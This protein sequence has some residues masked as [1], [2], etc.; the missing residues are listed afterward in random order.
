MDIGT[1]KDINDYTVGGR[2]I[3][4]HLIDIVDPGY[5]YNLFEY[6]QDFLKAYNDIISRK[7]F[8]VICGGSGMYVD[9]IVSGYRLA[10]VPPD[11]ILRQEL[12]HLTLEELTSVLST[13]KRMHNTTDVDS[14]K[15]AIRAI[16]IEKYYL[17]LQ[18]EEKEFP[19]IRSLVVG[20]KFDREERRKRISERLRQRFDS[21][22]VEEVEGLMENGVS[23]ETLIWY[24]LE[25]KYITLYLL[26]RTDYDGM[27]RSLETAI[28]QFAK[29]QMTWFR[30]MERRGVKINWIDGSLPVEEKVGRVL[31]LL[32]LSQ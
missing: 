7:R 14:K 13:M 8:P 23:S 32:N 25:Y 22:M 31:E 12:D 5:K 15:R 10:E 9:S 3:P 16:E 26:G 6:R 11:P 4:V 19:K 28:H 29:R 20:L 24:G 17:R 30:G 2:K 1:G 21:G 18:P 27:F